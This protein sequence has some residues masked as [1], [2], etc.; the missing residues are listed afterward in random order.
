MA[1][2]MMM[3]FLVRRFIKDYENVENAKVRTAYGML[4]GIGNAVSVYC[5]YNK[6]ITA[7][8]YIIFNLADLLCHITFCRIKL[9][10]GPCGFNS[11]L[12]SI[13]QCQYKIVSNTWHSNSDLFTFSVR[14]KHLFHSVCNSLRCILN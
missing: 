13:R 11:I 14:L 2:N 4:A 9:Y 12:H 6:D 3:D 5:P 7:H 10:L 1:S 8:G